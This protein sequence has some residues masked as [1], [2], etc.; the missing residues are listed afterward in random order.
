MH[1]ERDGDE[2]L[3][4]VESEK[5]N[6]DQKF[7]PLYDFRPITIAGFDVGLTPERF[8]EAKHSWCCT[9]RLKRSIV[10]RFRRIRY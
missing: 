8:L 3:I 6:V 5:R 9:E 1:I 7:V 2:E 4:V 10:A